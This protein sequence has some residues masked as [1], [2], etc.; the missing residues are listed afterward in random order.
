MAIK[1]HPSLAVHPGVWLRREVTEVCSMTAHQVADHLHVPEQ[2][3][4]HL[5]NGETNLTADLAI[6]F[7]KAF[8]IPA[9]T[10]MQMQITYDLAQ[11]QGNESI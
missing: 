10:M 7:E 11:S 5:L 1:L 3:I 4:S 9:D 6:R 8:A 2:I